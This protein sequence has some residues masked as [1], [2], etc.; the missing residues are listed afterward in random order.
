MYGT[1][2]GMEKTTVYLTTAQKAALADAARVQGRSEARLIRDG[3][4]GVLS[5]HRAGEVT[6]PL[7]SDAP[8]AEPAADDRTVRPRWM[9]RDA[10]VGRFGG[11]QADAALR[12][13]L[14]DLAPDLTD[15]EA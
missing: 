4:D 6:A 15:G 14:H 2:G 1:L 11:V 8:S 10:F 12:R 7:S 13:E 3:I 5:R 9:T